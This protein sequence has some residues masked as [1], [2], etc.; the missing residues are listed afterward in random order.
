[1]ILSIVS[2]FSGGCENV[3]TL[4]K[5]PVGLNCWLF[6]SPTKCFCGDVLGP[7]CSQRNGEVCVKLTMIMILWDTVDIVSYDDFPLH[8]FN[9]PA[10]FHILN[11]LDLPR[12]HRLKL[13]WAATTLVRWVSWHPGECQ[14]SWEWSCLGMEP[15]VYI[16]QPWSYSVAWGYLCEIWT[17]F[18][19]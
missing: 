17:H 9:V 2:F 12:C 3:S 16:N 5:A 18:K 10:R 7:Q 8:G 15:C 1:M 11:Q 13:R 19:T 6:A 4:L 14:P